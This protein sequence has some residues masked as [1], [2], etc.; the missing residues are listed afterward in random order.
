[1]NILS[2]KQMRVVIVGATGMV[3]VEP[4]PEVASNYTCG[5]LLETLVGTKLKDGHL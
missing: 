4:T 3:G 5:A 1:M 2:E